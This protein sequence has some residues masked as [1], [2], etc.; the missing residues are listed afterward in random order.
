MELNRVDN[1]NRKFI[2]VQLP[3]KTD[4]KEY[5]SISH[6]TRERVR[7][8]IKK[9][10]EADAGKFDF[11]N[12]AKQDRGFKAFK[13]SSSNFK[14]WE[15][16][17]TKVADVNETLSL[18]TDNIMPGRSQEDILYELLS[19]AGYS[20]SAPVERLTLAGKDVIT[21][22]SGDLLI[23]LDKK[24]TLE[25]IEEMVKRKPARILCLDAGFHGNDQLKVNVVQTVKSHNRKHESDIVFQ[26]V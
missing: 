13:L 6:I 17:A 14:V 3:E 25:V 18:F 22:A 4:I 26:V 23:C 9:M 5:P 8:A 21:V 12:T 24:L 7:R 1:G 15:G 11:D 2:L 16:N 19:K 20:L 10:N